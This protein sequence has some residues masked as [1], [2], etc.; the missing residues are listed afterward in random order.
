MN[1]LPE[2]NSIFYLC[3]KE[4]LRLFFG[5]KLKV[6]QQVEESLTIIT[7]KSFVF[8]L[9]SLGSEKNVDTTMFRSATWNYIHL[10]MGIYHDDYLY[11]EVMD[12][13]TLIILL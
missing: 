11:T 6:N 4:T 3:E 1:G 5:F 10:V 8:I 2:I 13:T 9:S 7:H 12:R